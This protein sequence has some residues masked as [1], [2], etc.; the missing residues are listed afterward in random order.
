MQLESSDETND[1][2][3]VIRLPGIR[4][5]VTAS[6]ITDQ[7]APEVVYTGISL[8]GAPSTPPS[9]AVSSLSTPQSSARVSLQTPSTPRIDI[10]RASSSSHHED[11]RSSTP[12]RELFG[13]HDTVKSTGIGLGFGE[14][15][16]LDLRSST[17]ELDFQDLQVKS[18]KSKPRSQ[19]PYQQDR[20][21]SQ[22]SEIGLLSISGRTSRL[23]SVGSQ[24]STHSRMS[25]VSHLSIISGQS[26]MSRSPSPHKML[27]ETSFCGSKS[28]SSAQKSTERGTKTDGDDLEVVL[29]SRKRDPTK[30][31]LAEGIS[32][33]PTNE[34][35]TTP[36][37]NLERKENINNVK[38]DVTITIDTSCDTIESIPKLPRTIISSSGVEYTYIPLKG[39]LPVNTTEL[40][41]KPV[42]RTKCAINNAKT[43][44]QKKAPA[45]SADRKLNKIIANQQELRSDEPKYIRIKLKPDYMYDD[46]NLN[47]PEV[48]KPDF[49][50]LKESIPNSTRQHE[51]P[52][53][54]I[55]IETKVNEFQ[56]RSISSTPSASPKLSRHNILNVCTSK[57]PSPS[58]S[59]KSS[60][61]SL[62]KS[63]EGAPS[64]ESP[65]VPGVRRKSTLSGILKE[66][67]ENLRERRRSRSK[68]RDRERGG[69]STAPSS[70]ESIDSK[71]KQKTILSIFKSRKCNDKSKS[72]SN[73]RSTDTL[74][75]LDGLS[76]VEFIFNPDDAQPARRHKS[77][78]VK[79]YHENQL[80]SDSIRIP[81]HSPTYYEQKSILQ[82]FKS[83]SRSSQETVIEVLDNKSIEIIPKD[84]QS[85]LPTSNQVVQN[86]VR[87]NSTSS[88]N[89]VFSTRLGSDNELFTIKFPR[90]KEKLLEGNENNH[91]AASHNLNNDLVEILY[92]EE[93]D[94]KL[95]TGKTTKA[96]SLSNLDETLS[97]MVT[98][99]AIDKETT[100]NSLPTDERNSSES[101]RDS[102]FDFVREKQKMELKLEEKAMDA[103]EIERK[104]LVLQQDSFEDELPYVPTTLPLERSVALPIVPIKQ[105]TFETKTFPIDRPRSTTP[106]NPNCLEEYCEEVICSASSDIVEKL[107]ISLPKEEQIKSP[108]RSGNL[109]W[110]DFSEKKR[111]TQRR[112]SLSHDGETSPPP[113]PPKGVQREWVNFEDIPEKRKPPKRIQTIPSR[114]NID[115]VESVLHD[116]VVYNYVNPEDCKCECHEINAKERGLQGPDRVDPV[117]EDELPLLQNEMGEDEKI[118]VENVERVK[119]DVKII[120]RRSIIR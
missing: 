90:A 102:E 20:K 92:D 55:K 107:K 52:R 28:E 44:L 35:T 17:E 4:E 116:N 27:L 89:I 45:G 31:I 103:L 23:S 81:L 75:N 8:I 84:E 104:G 72:E 112:S 118:A 53:K 100:P 115:I 76:N 18:S 42:H 2:G 86:K 69:L 77:A 63:K 64:P 24:G 39:P 36:P 96:K 41:S 25:N 82:E 6:C 105:R 9:A 11:S 91:V 99:P 46:R 22:S 71:G 59:R 50:D 113:L 40:N 97:N 37:K 108:R 32:V 62:F 15:G 110:H 111:T 65:T 54:E 1:I 70:A 94:P 120:D 49:L 109:N 74:P 10:S 33:T 7:P 48:Q 93:N 3:S 114:G 98:Y 119:L 68:S 101:E 51:V 13:A 95:I 29:L 12:E 117:Q 43:T 26:G 5:D 57:S 88:E 80:E 34:I 14:D 79:M 60:F 47:R 106:I 56:G 83:Q 87:Q 21:D 73:A 16:A 19:S 78:P 38:S 85:K 67:G 30:V 66:A 58:L 61:A